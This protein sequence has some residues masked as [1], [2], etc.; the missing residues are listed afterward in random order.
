MHAVGLKV[1]HFCL[2]N[3]MEWKIKVEEKCE[4]CS[5]LLKVFLS[6]NSIKAISQ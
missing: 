6:I 5:R 1:Q 3:G 4:L 2:Q